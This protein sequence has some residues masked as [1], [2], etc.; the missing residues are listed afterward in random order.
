MRRVSASSSRPS[1]RWPSQSGTP[2]PH[3]A[4]NF[5]TWARVFTGMMPGTIGTVMPAAAQRSRKRR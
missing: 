1:K 2:A 3:M 5:R 4:L